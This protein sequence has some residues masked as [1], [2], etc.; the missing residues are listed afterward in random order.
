M[1][2]N[3]L[4]QRQHFILIRTLLV[5]TALALLVYIAIREIYT[6]SGHLMATNGSGKNDGTLKCP[7]E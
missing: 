4:K 5:V 2:T 7:P 1:D 6:G 3:E